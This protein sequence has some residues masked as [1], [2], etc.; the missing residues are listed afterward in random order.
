MAKFNKT[1]LENAIKQAC[2]HIGSAWEQVTKVTADIIEHCVENN[3]D[4]SL[5]VKLISS[6]EKAEGRNGNMSKAIKEACFKIAGIALKRDVETDSWFGKKAK[7]ANDINED[8]MAEYLADL[9]QKGLRSFLP[10]PK[11]SA[12]K[13]GVKN[14]KVTQIKGVG[15]EQA[16]KLADA[17]ADVAAIDKDDPELVNIQREIDALLYRLEERKKELMEKAKAKQ[18]EGLKKSA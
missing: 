4:T 12:G 3:Y 8:V 15:T 13:G 11:A 2:G 16:V 14:S 9:R 7:S 17:M 18:A 6:V 5:A 1:D 10:K